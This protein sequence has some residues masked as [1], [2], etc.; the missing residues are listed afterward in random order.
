M[1]NFINKCSNIYGYGQIQGR[2]INISKKTG[3]K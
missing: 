1:K 3:N 2:D